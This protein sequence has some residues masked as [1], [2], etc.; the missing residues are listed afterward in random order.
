MATEESN[1]TE[2]KVIL[3]TKEYR[4]L[5]EDNIRFKHDA[6]GARRASWDYESKWHE[7]EKKILRLNEKIKQYETYVSENKLTENFSIFLIRLQ[8]KTIEEVED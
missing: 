6:D 3:S 2:G 5:I 8:N 7:A 1:Y 4:D